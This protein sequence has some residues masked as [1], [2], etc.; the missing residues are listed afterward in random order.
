MLKPHCDPKSI[1]MAIPAGG[2]PVGSVVADRLKL[3][4][5][6][7]VVSK[8]TLPWNTEAGYGAIAFDGTVKLN[9]A[10]LRRL[11]LTEEDIQKGIKKTKQKVSRRVLELRGSRLFPTLKNR[12]IILIDDGVASGFTMKVAITALQRAGAA[13]VTVA[14]PTAHKESVE[15]I[16]KAVDDVFCPNLR[17]G[18]QFAVASA[19]EKWSDV[20]EQG[21]IHILENSNSFQM[22]TLGE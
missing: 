19:Y 11:N 22:A 20:T 17:S 10:L 9:Q 16:L 8:I 5:D 3:P 18:R 7:A 13:H 15:S 2:I 21:V 6:V 4:L 12:K 14:I 1:V